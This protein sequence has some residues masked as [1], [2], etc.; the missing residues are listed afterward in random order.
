MTSKNSFRLA[1]FLLLLLFAGNNFLCAQSLQ[2]Q[3]SIQL[4]GPDQGLSDRAVRRVVQDDLGYLWIGAG[5]SLW[6]YDGYSFNNY[7]DLLS[8]GSD[9]ITLV[10][11]LVV[12]PDKKIWVAHSNGLTIFDPATFEHTTIDVSKNLSGRKLISRQVTKFFFSNDGTAWLSLLGNTVMKVDKSGRRLFTVNIPAKGGEKAV[13]K[14]SVFKILEDKFGRAYLFSLDHYV[15]IIDKK[16]RLLRDIEVF[17]EFYSKGFVPTNMSLSA[18]QNILINYRTADR[19]QKFIREYSY[20]KA[21]FISLR[22]D[23][24][25]LYSDESLTAKDGTTW[26]RNDKQV[27]FLNSQRTT[28]TNLT[29]EIFEKAGGETFFFGACLSS[30]NTYWLC[31]TAG[32]FKI[33]I[34]EPLFRNYLSASLQKPTDIGTSLR[35]ITEDS[36]GHLWV[37]SYG[38]KKDDKTYYLHE[39]CPQTAVVK[40][41]QIRRLNDKEQEEYIPDYV[42]YKII[43]SKAGMYSITDGTS[44]LKLKREGSIVK[45]KA[46]DGISLNEF[47]SIY[48]VNDSVLWLGS[49]SGMVKM[50]AKTERAILLN[51]VAGNY[52]KNI[53]LNYFMPWSSGRFLVST[54]NG[55]YVL[56]SSAEIVEHYGN[57]AEDKIKL[58]VQSVLYTVWYGQNLWCATPT[59]LLR[60][61]TVS[62]KTELYTTQH[63]LP[64]NNVYT[65]LPDDQGNLWLSTNNGLCRFNVK[66]RKAHNYG[67]TDGL[68]HMEFNTASYLKAHDGKLY[69]GG[70]NGV[71]SFDPAKLNTTK[72]EETSLQLISF[73]KY[74]GSSNRM[75]TAMGNQV[76]SPIQ[77]SS[78]DRFLTFVFMAPDFRHTDQNRFRYKLQGWADDDWHLFETGNRL[79]FNS[80]PAG[81]YQLQVQVSAGGADWSSKSWTATIMVK[82]PW[83]KTAWFYGL[84]LLAVALICYGVYR[85]RLNQI[86]SIYQIRNRISA[87]MHDE[88]GST[89]SSISF[90]SQALL[91]QQQNEKQKEVLL[92]IKDNAQQVQ[93]GLSDIIWSV[94]ASLDEMEN[95]FSR[96]FR[97]GSELLESKGIQF[98]FENDEKLQHQKLTMTQRKNFYLVFKEALNNA[99]K[100]SSCK[101][102]WVQIG[103]QQHRIQMTIRDDGKGFNAQEIRRGNGLSNM[104]E[105]AAQINGRLTVHSHEQEGTTVVLLF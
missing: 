71:I 22:S 17:S 6:R 76:K 5:T 27:G 90:Y 35:G 67:L 68:P 64:D 75:E 85:Y 42:L 83:Y 24:G 91:M 50:N 48:A 69:F 55:L 32:L 14:R 74:A 63:G 25:Y 88:I 89:L 72:E 93:E 40:H 39:V 18:D 7:T 9:T 95:V 94:K 59:G 37:C 62:R 87:D 99:A 49:V 31:S 26:V 58:P 2:T 21:N 60:I 30:D 3:V 45:G 96:M 86:I 65:C 105:R 82:A 11:D 41:H 28:F 34:F 44:L 12:A 20:D 52:I 104:E 33:S 16:G 70:L 1:A 29:N 56:N 97:F 57:R 10:N 46:Y 100:Y 101:N 36:A 13:G 61:D 66:T 54:S 38:F 77:F 92:K 84:S 15:Y 8:R 79:S 19:K 51:S 80:L 53:R 103:K 81:T 102:V 43:F 4:L 23:T 98:H 78:G 73:S 47:T